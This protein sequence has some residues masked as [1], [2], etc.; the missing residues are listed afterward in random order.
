MLRQQLDLA[1][2]LADQIQEAQER[3]NRLLNM[4]ETL[5]LQ[6][7]SLKARSA[8][9]DFDSSEISQKVRS[10]AEDVQRYNEATEE[11]VKLLAEE[12]SGPVNE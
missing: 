7:A 2:G 12:R 10:I 6:V 9:D 4:L 3:R 1:Q 11:T 5:W 8:A